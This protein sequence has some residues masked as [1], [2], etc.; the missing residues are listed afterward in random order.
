MQQRGLGERVALAMPV[1]ETIV[2]RSVCIQQVRQVVQQVARYPN[3]TVLLQGES[4]TGKEVVAHAIHALSARASHAF[5]DINCAALPETLIETELFGAESGA[6]TD[7]KATHEGHIL[8]ADGGTLFLDEVGEMPLLMQPKL[9]R[10]LENRRFRRVGGVRELHV[11][12][13][14]ISATNVDLRRAIAKQTFREDLF[15]RLNVVPIQLPP[16]RERLE[17]IE[18]LVEHYLSTLATDM[19]QPTLQVSPDA[20]TL[21]TRYTWPGNIR[22]LFAVLQSGS[23]LCEGNLIMPH[24]LPSHLLTS[25]RDADVQVYSLA[26]HFHLPPE[27]L[28]LPT[29][30]SSIEQTLVCEALARCNGNQVK[31]AALLHLSRDQLRYRLPRP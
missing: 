27:G 22:E 18:L 6:F 3:V 28:D 14:I 30:L 29:F 10:F 1:E 16:L 24:D 31:A 11:D 15:Y 9:L 25:Q 20:L 4:G 12:T 17:D 7:A 8:R 26:T 5:V 2:G 13:R 23:I 19:R 21:L